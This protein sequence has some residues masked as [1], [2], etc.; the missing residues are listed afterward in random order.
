MTSPPPPSRKLQD[1]IDAVGFSSS[2]KDFSGTYMMAV[3]A[4]FLRAMRGGDE[5]VGDAVTGARYLAYVAYNVYAD[6]ARSWRR[7]VPRQIVEVNGQIISGE[8]VP[9]ANLPMDVQFRVMQV[10]DIIGNIFFNL[11]GAT[12][13]TGD[14]VR[15]ATAAVG[16]YGCGEV[17][18]DRCGTD[19]FHV[20]QDGARVVLHL[21]TAME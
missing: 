15:Q 9:L 10:L 5:A 18:D 21:R 17:V 3:N 4:I 20:D 14:G 2:I 8:G 6:S 16:Q 1:K 7:E 19:F 12:G 11:P 13:D